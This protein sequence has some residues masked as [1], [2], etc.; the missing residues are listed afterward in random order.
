MIYGGTWEQRAA[1]A[2]MPH[3][4]LTGQAR[5]LLAGLDP[6]ALAAIADAVIGLLDELRDPDEDQCEAGD[7]GCGVVAVGN[8]AG[9]MWGAGGE[10]CPETTF[11]AEYGLDQRAVPLSNFVVD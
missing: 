3:E 9:L 4:A 7:D 5:A 8:G 2:V 6:F 10:D 1:R 11:T